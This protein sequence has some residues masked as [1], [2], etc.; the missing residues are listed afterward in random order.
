MSSERFRRQ[1]ERRY[2]QDSGNA[3]RRKHA[4]PAVAHPWIA[5]SR[6]EKLGT[7]V[8]A[9]HIVLEYGVGPGWNLESIQ[10]RERLGYDLDPFLEKPLAAKGIRFVSDIN[11]LP[12]A[13]VDIIICHHVL[14]HTLHP[15]QVL[16][17]IRRMLKDDARLVLMVPY[18][19]Q[20]NGRRFTPQQRDHHLYAW[21]VQTLG[22]LVADLGFSIQQA[23]IGRYGWDRFLAVAAYRLKIGAIGFRCLKK[24]ALAV[25]P[26]WE[27]RIVAVKKASA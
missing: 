20:R 9:D 4:V 14:E 11:T 6:A 3:Y 27:V 1:V 17:D 19:M 5:A 23:G 24:I 10:C 8:Q 18:E 25:H 13:S 16:G 15:A 26:L 12:K 21:N 2:G 7:Y 22:N